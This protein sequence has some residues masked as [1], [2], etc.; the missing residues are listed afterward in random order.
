MEL[1]VS[2]I[3]CSINYDKEKLI[4]AIEKLGIEEIITRYCWHTE[5]EDRDAI[6]NLITKF[7]NDDWV[8]DRGTPLGR[9]FWGDL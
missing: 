3:G 8:D 5:T 4:N 1:N 2:D 9:Y 6:S 7:L